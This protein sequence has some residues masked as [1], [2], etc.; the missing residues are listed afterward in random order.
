MNVK[1]FANNWV[2]LGMQ[3]HMLMRKFPLGKGYIK[4]GKLVWH[5]NLDLG[6]EHGQYKIK[7]LYDLHSSPQVF[8]IEPNLYEL[9]GGAKPPHIYVFNEDETK[10]CLFYPS[11]G[12]WAA[13]KFLSD[14]IV[15]WA[16]LWLIYF[17]G[18][19][20]TGK[21]YGGGK[22]PEPSHI[23]KKRGMVL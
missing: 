19:M 12:E 21:W 22:H 2:S 10:L 6:D 8:V 15:P 1:Q 16:C 11:S 9:T 17:N 14:T 13:N 3:L 23:A 7:L 18:W 5:C 4:K 20:A